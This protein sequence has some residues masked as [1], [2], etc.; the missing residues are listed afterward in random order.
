MRFTTERLIPDRPEL[1]PMLVWHM[2]RYRFAEPLV[3]GA[4][5]LDAGCG[6]G[7]G[8]YHLATNGAKRVIGVDIATEAIEY[9]RS[10][11][12]SENLEFAMTDV[13]TLALPSE[14]LDAV[15][16][17]EVFEHVADSERLLAECR[18]VLKPSGRII[19]STPNK[20]V[21]SPGRSEPVN[22]WHV[23]EYSRDEFAGILASYF[24]DL[25]LWGQASS[26]PG[27]SSITLLHLHVQR[28]LLSSHSRF[29]KALEMGYGCVVKASG[30]V[31]RAALALM[32][33][34]PNV[35]EKAEQL[36]L[37]DIQ[38]F[39]AAGRKRAHHPL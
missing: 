26:T 36:A 38:Y 20:Q 33:K 32:G 29:S 24:E 7:Y 8:S 12:S 14:T 16:C 35:I 17:L 39:I 13:R 6:C 22:P 25:E 23:R 30:L 21:F 18:R 4:V 34:A 28:Y 1:Q 15:V 10:H 2:A 37:Q 3:H 11:Y 9:A 5:V 19:V 27:L 31:A